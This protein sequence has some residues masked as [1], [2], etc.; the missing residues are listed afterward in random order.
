MK[1]TWLRRDFDG[2][3]DRIPVDVL[4]KPRDGFVFVLAHFQ[5]G[6][7]KRRVSIKNLITWEK[8]PLTLQAGE[9]RGAEKQ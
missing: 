9:E 3:V 7:I 8:L 1:A 5:R 2:D 6:T 4:D